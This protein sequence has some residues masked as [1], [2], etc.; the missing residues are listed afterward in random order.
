M[1]ACILLR[2]DGGILFA[3][4]AGYW[5]LVFLR[6]IGLGQEATSRSDPAPRVLPFLS[7]GAILTVCAFA[8][9][10]PWTLRNLHTMH[11]FQPLAPRYATESDEHPMPG[12][13]RW[14][15]T[16]MADYTSVQEI[17]WRVP[18]DAIDFTRLPQRAFDSSGERQATEQLF[19]DYNQDH[20]VTSER[21][22]RF[23]A[24]A[25]ARI[26]AAPLRYYL[27][28]PAA[29]IADMW[30]R[31]RTE[32]LPSDPRWWE[33]DDDPTWLTVSIVFGLIGLAYVAAA[34]A[35]VWRSRDSFGIGLLVMF[36]VL[37]SLFLGTLENPEPRYTLECYPAVI[38]MAAA[39]LIDKFHRNH[40]KPA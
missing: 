25:A 13:N 11:R 12:F 7:V 6:R 3:A 36:V 5:L 20:E 18:G 14:I 28:L 23:A 39:F 8:P 10:I 32:L 17:Y 22:A 19:A 35:G 29:R 37:R 33:F 21:D 24:L 27:W 34:A 4:V 1:G 2:P 30:L 16:W 31:P 38:V 40:R 26:H 9:L 15:N